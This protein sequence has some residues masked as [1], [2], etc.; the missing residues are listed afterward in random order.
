MGT[1]SPSHFSESSIKCNGIF[2]DAKKTV[3]TSGKKVQHVDMTGLFQSL[4]VMKKEH[5]VQF[6]ELG[7]GVK[8]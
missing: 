8:R 5:M 2:S 7:S 6:H 3:L 1:R 4:T